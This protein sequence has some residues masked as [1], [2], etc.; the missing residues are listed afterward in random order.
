MMETRFR[1][2]FD[3]KFLQGL[4]LQTTDPQ[5][6]K[7]E[8][9]SDVDSMSTSLE[10]DQVPQSLTRVKPKSVQLAK[11]II[12]DPPRGNVRGRTQAQGQAPWLLANLFVLSALGV[13]VLA[14]IVTNF[15]F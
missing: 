7:K 13:L 8:T 12:T 15:A 14:I 6:P 10:S 5:S 3:Q 11:Q 2:L 4:P 9:F 1:C